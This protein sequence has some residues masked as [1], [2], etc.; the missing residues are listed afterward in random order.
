MTICPKGPRP[1][2]DPHADGLRLVLEL[3]IAQ[4]EEGAMP[5]Y[6]TSDFRLASGE[7]L[8]DL[9]VAYQTYGALNAEKS[10]AIIVMHGTTS[11]HHAAGRV[12]PD[13]REGWWDE[14]IGPGRLFD[15]DRYCVISSNML[16]SSYGSTGPG[17]I[18]PATGRPWGPDFPSITVED[19]VRAQNALIEGLG[20]GRLLLVAGQSVGGLL[21]F[22]WAVTFPDAMRGILA[23]DCG[24]VSR[25]GITAT[26][27][28]LIAELEGDPKWSGGRYDDGD[29]EEVMTRIRVR[30]L[31]AYQFADKFAGQMSEDEIE[32]LLQ[33][34]A[35]A[36]A[37]EF[38]PMSLVRLNEAF[39]DFDVSD[40][41]DRIRANFF[42]VL[43]DT[44]E[45]YPASIGS[46]V[47][48]EM[49][50]AGVEV[51]LHEVQSQMGHY[52][53]TAEPEKWVPQ[54]RAFLAGL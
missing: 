48:A 33:E 19:M 54:A 7:V 43:C 16:G 46:G 47:V 42:Y 40:Q 32:A 49:R 6:R 22:Q 15:T 23:T 10:N 24:P 4:G 20:I 50:E 1:I 18:N 30:T 39:G 38:D 31:R 51:T 34:T 36:W 44:D 9:T 13:L 5:E 17:S 45:F 12:T 2:P 25:F 35:R 14:I 41:L 28:D 29:L 21:A 3:L 26:L 27:P 52:S 53:T 11:T 37:R 8:P